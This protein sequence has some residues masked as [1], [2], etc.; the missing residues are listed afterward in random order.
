MTAHRMDIRLEPELLKQVREI[1]WTER[2]ASD[3]EAIR[4]L[5]ARGVLFTRGVDS[6]RSKRAA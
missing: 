3:S 2:L 6:R 1:R 4:V 5:L